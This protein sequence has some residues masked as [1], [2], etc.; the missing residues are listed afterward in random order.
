MR[1][2]RGVGDL[3]EAQETL[4]WAQ[5][6][7][8]TDRL[9]EEQCLATFAEHEP[10]LEAF[11]GDFQIVLDMTIRAQAYPWDRRLVTQARIEVPPRGDWQ[12]HIV[13]T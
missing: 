7:W 10:A 12:L 13:T 1:L 5:F 2:Y 3:D 6:L 4:G 8:N 9:P 11:V